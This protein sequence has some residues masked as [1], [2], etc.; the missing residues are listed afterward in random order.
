MAPRGAIYDGLR[1]QEGKNNG[2]KKPQKRRREEPEENGKKKI[3]M[4]EY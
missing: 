4:I 1:N 2:D 3:F